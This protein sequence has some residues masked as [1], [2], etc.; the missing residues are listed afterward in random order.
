MV[1]NRRREGKY[2]GVEKGAIKAHRRRGGVE[3]NA[4]DD[5]MVTPGTHEPLVDRDTWQRVAARLGAGPKGR[6]RTSWPFALLGLA[7]CGTCGAPM[8]GCV[9]R[10]VRRGTSYPRLVCGTY[11][12]LGR[13]L[14]PGG[15][16]DEAPVVRTLFR[17]LL[18]EFLDPANLEAL[19]AEMRQLVGRDQ[20]GDPGQA[21]SLRA[22][23]AEVSGNIER[24]AERLLAEPDP[25][26]VP[27]LR[28]KLQ[29]WQRQEAELRGRLEALGQTRRQAEDGERLVEEALAEMEALRK[30]LEDAD[31]RKR[32]LE[33][34]DRTALRGVVREV[35]SGADACFVS[36]PYGPGRVRRRFTHC[37]VHIRPDRIVARCA[38]IGLPMESL[39]KHLRILAPDLT[40]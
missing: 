1:W 4:P 37:D 32:P 6:P 29:E 15:R 39:V 7:R 18:R 2:H 3:F 17:V 34:I 16:V 8:Y 12:A 11:H 13:S 33:G 22:R 36:A 21:R 20:A 14:C 40:D 31:P 23:L 25:A 5:V 30:R 9:F 19:R 24:G 28:G 26:L 38:P 35:V 10:S 27:V